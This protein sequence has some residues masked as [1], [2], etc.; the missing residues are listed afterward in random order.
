VLGLLKK[1]QNCL[2]LYLPL[3]CTVLLT[4][5]VGI[6]V[7]GDSSQIPGNK[8]LPILSSSLLNKIIKADYVLI[9]EE[10]HNLKHH[11]FQAHIIKKIGQYRP[12]LVSLEHFTH[13]QQHHLN[14]FSAGQTGVNNL[15]NLLSWTDSGWPPFHFFTPILEALRETNALII[16]G[17]RKKYEPDD[18]LMLYG[19]VAPLPGES[20]L[21]KELDNT[22]Q[23]LTY[24]R[25]YNLAHLQRRRDA[26]LA[27][28]LDQTNEGRLRLLLAG[29]GHVK[30]NIGVQWYIN[31]RHPKARVLTIG[32][33]SHPLSKEQQT[34]FDETVIIKP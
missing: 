10:H 8:D 6:S 15:E 12:L 24:N 17:N 3:T 30:K 32:L 16:A 29:N 9:G 14:R 19:L 26:S 21:K 1:I 20:R 5:G 13:D 33:F 11:L 18:D 25:S 7:F 28:S 22:H 27:A 2:L 23:G 34:W 4:I 31:F